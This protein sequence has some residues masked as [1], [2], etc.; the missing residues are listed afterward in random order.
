MGKAVNT[1]VQNIAAPVKKAVA[2]ISTDIK[3]GKPLNVVKDLGKASVNLTKASVGFSPD[4]KFMGESVAKAAVA[5]FKSDPVGALQQAGTIYAT[6]GAS[7][8]PTL[9]SSVLQAI[10]AGTPPAKLKSGGG[11]AAAPTQDNG[12]PP[13]QVVVQSGGAQTMLLVAGAVVVLALVLRRR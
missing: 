9:D 8:L 4:N 13:A 7:L 10:G 12:A 11:S 1:A 5:D 6:G 3:E 2:D